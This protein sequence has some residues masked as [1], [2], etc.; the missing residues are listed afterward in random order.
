ME[1]SKQVTIAGNTGEGGQGGDLRHFWTG[2]WQDL[3]MSQLQEIM[4]N[5]V[6]KRTPRALACLTECQSIH[7]NGEDNKRRAGLGGEVGDAKF[8]LGHVNVEM[9]VRHPNRSGK[10]TRCVCIGSSKGWSG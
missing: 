2:D 6:S 7:S 3:V 8:R 4:K 1:E 9:R 10:S 5:E